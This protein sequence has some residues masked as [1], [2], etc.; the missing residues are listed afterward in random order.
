MLKYLTIRLFYLQMHMIYKETNTW[1]YHFAEVGNIPYST[2]T[3]AHW[4]ESQRLLDKINLNKRIECGNMILPL[5][6]CAKW[7]GSGKIEAAPAN[8]WILGIP[9]DDAHTLTDLKNRWIGPALT[10][11]HYCSGIINSALC[12]QFEISV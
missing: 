10:G 12:M 3:P 6:S 7:H 4:A 11:K 9:T 8:M 5:W 1:T 2:L